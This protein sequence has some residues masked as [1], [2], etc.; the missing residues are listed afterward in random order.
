LHANDPEEREQ[1]NE[2]RAHVD[3]LRHRVHERVD[4]P[5]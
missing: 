4:L 3:Q 5:M 1:E 2:E